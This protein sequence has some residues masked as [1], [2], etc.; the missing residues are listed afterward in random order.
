MTRISLGSEVIHKVVFELRYHHGFEFW[1]FA[2][3]VT[4]DI[5][6]KNPEFD[7]Q[8][9]DGDAVH[10]ID[11]DQNLN[12]NFGHRKLDLSQQQSQK[13]PNVMDLN[14]LGKLAETLSDSVVRGLHLARCIESLCHR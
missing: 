11:R 6:A 10:L 9:M 4:N 8:A 1:D 7:V 5:L 12:F 2:G 14:E 13:C 3:R